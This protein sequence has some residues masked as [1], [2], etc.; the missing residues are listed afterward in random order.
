MV[1]SL[2]SATQAANTLDVTQA[3][4]AQNIASISSGSPFTSAL[5]DPASQAITNALRSDIGADGQALRNTQQASAL[6]QTAGGG[7]NNLSGTLDRLSQL[8]VQA[9]NGALGGAEQQAIRAEFGELLQQF[10][11]TVGGTRFNG[12]Q[13]LAGDGAGGAASF[14]FQVGGDAGEDLAVSIASNALADLGLDGLDP[15]SGDTLSVLQNAAASVNSNLA[16]VGAQQSNFDSVLANTESQILGQQGALGSFADTDL[17]GALIQQ[18]S[19]NALSN[20]GASLIAQT[21]NLTEER[22]NALLAGI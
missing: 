9:G 21:S 1:N 22:A 3:R 14:N 15:F 2:G 8:A 7:L 12:Q 13:L 5:V 18:A 10:G 11:D 4:S 19:D 20:A 17:V 16:T 6:L